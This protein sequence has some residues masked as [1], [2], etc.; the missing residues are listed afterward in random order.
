MLI[1]SILLILFLGYLFRKD[2]FKKDFFTSMTNSF[3]GNKKLMTI[4][5]KYNEKKINQQN[6]LNKLLD[7]INE[8]GLDSLS[9]KEKTKLEELSRN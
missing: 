2:L 9:E 5:D 3:S 6:D 8:K 4:E 7:K 1:P